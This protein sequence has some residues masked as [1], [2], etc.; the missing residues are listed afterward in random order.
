MDF[1]RTRTYPFGFV[2]SVPYKY[3][4]LNWVRYL[5]LAPFESLM[6]LKTLQAKNLGLCFDAV[7]V[8]SVIHKIRKISF[9]VYLYLNVEYNFCSTPCKVCVLI[10]LENG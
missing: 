9:M 2:W 6:P 1:K 10:V 7:K 5:S 8:K 4:F 3:R